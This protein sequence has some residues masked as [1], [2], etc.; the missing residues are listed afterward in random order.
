MHL[1]GPSEDDHLR[2]DGG[3]DSL[4]VTYAGGLLSAVLAGCRCRHATHTHRREALQRFHPSRS[5]LVSVP[6]AP[7]RRGPMRDRQNR[8]SIGRVVGLWRYPVKS[9]APEPLAAIA[10]S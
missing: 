2:A 4:T 10:P 7:L 6:R 5:T 3:M 9:M 8:T 1:R